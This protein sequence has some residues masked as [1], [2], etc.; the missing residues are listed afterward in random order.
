MRKRLVSILLCLVMIVGLLPMGVWADESGLPGA[1]SE[2]NTSG[3]VFLGGNYIEVG[4]SKHGSFGTSKTPTNESFHPFSA[5]SGIGLRVDGDGW[6]VGNE[7]NTG[8]FFLPG[9]EEERWILAYCIGDTEYEY[10]VADRRSIIP[11]SVW[12][13]VPSVEDK[14]DIEKGLLKAV[15]TGITK[16]NVE[17]TI[18]YSFGA[19]DKFFTTDVSITNKGEADISRVRFVRSFDPDMDAETKN[20]YETFNKVICNPKADDDATEGGDNN[21]AMVVARGGDSLEGFFFIA[22]DERARASIR[23]GSGLAPSSAYEDYLWNDAVETEYTYAAPG[24]LTMSKDDTNGYKLDDDA[25][26]LTFSL[27]TLV[28]NTGSTSLQLI[29]SLDPDVEASLGKL[30]SSGVE[31]SGDFAETTATGLDTIAAGLAAL[32]E[33][34]D[35]DIKVTLKVD[36]IDAE[37]AP[38]ALEITAKAGEDKTLSFID[39]TLTAKVGTADPTDIGDSNTTLLKIE[40]PFDRTG[41]QDIAVYRFHDADNNGAVDD[42]EITELGQG[43]DKANSEG[44][45]CVVGDTSITVYAKKFSTYA[46]AYTPTYTV[47]VQ[48]GGNGSAAANLT[49]AAAGTE[50]TLSATAADGYRFKE[51]QVLSGGITVAGNKFIMPATNVTVK[52]IFEAVPSSPPIYI[53]PYVPPVHSCE[54]IC[55]VCGGCGDAKCT[56]KVCKDKCILLSMEFDDV[57]EGQWYTEGVKYV[58]HHDIMNGVDYGRFHVDGTLTRAM[59]VTV[60]WRLEGEPIVDYDMSFVDV[61]PTAWYGE[62]VRWAASEGIVTGYNEREFRTLSPI[63]NEQFAAILWRYA[64]YKDYDVSADYGDIYRYRD[65]YSISDYAFTAMEWA[66]DHGVL[67]VSGNYL[68]PNADTLRGEAANLLMNFCENIRDK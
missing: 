45:Y 23:T 21:Y 26:A 35:K 43:S 5:S 22:F 12:S 33:N 68:K 28:K 38:G 4:I 18:T 27:G 13:I 7:P 31:G 29:S 40:L 64:K 59:M 41:R 47:T 57:E 1:R 60:L 10:A 24:A 54:S 42:G 52:A 49:T 44:E 61:S 20:T 36:G 6:G 30:T 25:I 16:E 66:L 63:T 46:I 2:T 32:P 8:D 53:P 51:W 58:Y 48:S 19:D 62:A 17:F 37:T 56:E 67:K 14:S 65:V 11:D 3:D 15:V 55:D 39:M 34:A 9:T 50:I